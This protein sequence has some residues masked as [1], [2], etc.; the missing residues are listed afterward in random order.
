[1][2]DLER[3]FTLQLIAIALIGLVFMAAALVLRER[4]PW[5]FGLDPA[6]SCLAL[7]SALAILVGTVTPRGARFSRGRIQLIP[8]RTLRRYTHDPSDLLIY[9]VGNVAL[10]VPL[11]FF[12]Y[13]ALRHLAVTARLIVTTLL[14]TQAS[15]GVEVLQLPIWSRSSD[16]DDVLTNTIGGF[17]GA[18]AG[19]VLLLLIRA[20]R[21][22]GNGPIRHYRP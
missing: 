5:R 2:Q 18:L 22:S 15:L 19:Y 12:L 8:L 16:V 11:G 21:I 17:I 20:V 9:L 14:C 6:A 13:L 7:G 10:F 4:E 1:M 3:D